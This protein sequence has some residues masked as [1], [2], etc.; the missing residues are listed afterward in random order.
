MKAFGVAL[1][2]AF[3]EDLHALADQ[4]GVLRLGVGVDH[5]KEVLVARLLDLFRK[6]AGHGRGGCVAALGVPEHERVVEA[7]AVGQVARGL[8]IHV[9]LAGEADDDVRGD[10]HAGPGGAQAFDEVEIPRRRVG[11]VHGAQNPVAAALHGKMDVRHQPG[12]AR[13]G[14]HEVLPETDGMR[15]RE[16]QPFQPL[17]GVHGVE[18]LHERAAAV[19][20]L[21][22]FVASVEVDDLPEQRDFLDPTGHQRADLGDDFLQAAGA[23]RAAGVGHDAKRAAHVAALH[24]RHERARLAGP[25]D[26]FLDGFLRTGLFLDIDHGVAQVVA[27]AVLPWRVRRRARA[28]ST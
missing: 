9:R 1:A 26:M 27:A 15:R 13:E 12:Q 3:A 14:V 7:D 17:D 23:F 22:K 25:Q 20:G 11:P 16:A 21:G 4:R 5:G 19:G 24:D 8:V 6:L 10:R 28:S 18:Q 2:R